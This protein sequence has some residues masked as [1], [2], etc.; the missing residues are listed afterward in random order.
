L[1]KRCAQYKKDGCQFA[2]WRCVIKIS[3]HTP[4]HT[5][6]QE[7]ATVLAS[8]ASICQQVDTCDLDIRLV[9][10]LVVSQNGLVPIVEPEV[11]PDGNHDIH[12]TQKVTELALAYTYKALADHHVLLEGT[13]LK[14]NMV[15]AGQDCPR[16]ASTPQIA[17]ATVT[18]L[19]RTVPPAVPGSN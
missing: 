19:Q 8:Y 1:D 5:A 11:L 2:K 16:K 10:T 17:R 13:L 3:D 18:A 7:T 12:V 4:T 14:P 9:V 15:T 6:L